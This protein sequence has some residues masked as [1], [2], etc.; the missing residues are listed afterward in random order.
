MPQRDEDD[1]IVKWF[2]TCTDI[3]EQRQLEQNLE[4]AEEEAE[5]ASKAKSQFLANMSHE[6]RTPLNAVIGYSEMLVE[7]LEADGA[8]AETGKQKEQFLTDLDKIHDAGEQ[9]LDLIN[10][11]LDIAK[12]EAGEM[13]LHPTTSARCTSRRRSSGRRS[14]TCWAMQ[15]S[16]PKTGA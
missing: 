6:L 3:E 14:S 15:P 11:V 4:Q 1:Q 16:S 9:L 13:E 7:G 8:S 5:A 12:I 2:G 10:D